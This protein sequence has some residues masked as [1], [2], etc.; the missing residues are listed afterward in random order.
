[1]TSI[2]PIQFV[3]QGGGA[4]LVSLLAAAQAV[5]DNAGP[6]GYKITRVSGTSA[7]AIAACILASGQSPALFLQRLH[8]LADEYLDKITRASESS[9]SLSLV[10]SVVQDALKKY[11][12]T[13]ANITIDD[14]QIC[15]FGKL[16]DGVPI[17]D[18]DAYKAFL[19]DLFD[20]PGVSF[21]SLD[22]LAPDIDIL[23]HAVDIRTKEP[24]VYRKGSGTLI[25]DAL[26]DSSALP[27]I[28]RTFKSESG[29]FDGGLVNNF[30]SANLLDDMKKYGRVLGFTFE[31]EPMT[32]KF[33]NVKDFASGLV[34]TMI[35]GSTQSSLNLLDKHCV[36]HIRTSTATLD[37]QGAVENDMK[38]TIRYRQYVDDA[39]AFLSN[40]TMRLKLAD[41]S[42]SPT[43]L[44]KRINELHGAL[45]AAQSVSTPKVVCYLTSN[46]LHSRNKEVKDSC[47]IVADLKVS[48]SDA[49]VFGFRL[50]AEK[51]FSR[52]NVSLIDDFGQQI[53][54]T[55]IP[56]NAEL[57]NVGEN[58]LLTNNI[59]LFFH[60]PLRQG[61]TYKLQFVT[62]ATEVL[63]D[64]I[65]PQA[66]KD[67]IS[68]TLAIVEFVDELALVAYIPRDFEVGSQP[69]DPV[70]S[71][72]WIAGA[73]L[74]EE[75]LAAYD[76][77]PPGFRAVG[78]N[79]RDIR[80]GQ[81][82][83]FTLYNHGG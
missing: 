21:K 23:V 66:R 10:R 36:H 7:G 9:P 22:D 16:A 43:G 47:R 80:R 62:D 56:L 29:I 50:H 55:A 57:V 53:R 82:V 45:L 78:W 41:A 58:V 35:D 6:L 54:V 46:S 11:L 75:A 24:K 8:I 83:G 14:A 2:L 42:L 18:P 60:K 49:T 61:K 27:F 15:L 37:F 34:A 44:V 69:M 48:G 33:S 63:Y 68:F 25:V 38:N 13:S 71:A 28:F 19:V 1:M 76:L 81:A 74:D 73:A 40:A 72:T 64:L 17:F 30:P 4:K 65:D 79:A 12:A 59:L 51:E 20:L 77:P 70:G 26:F 3:F 39:A 67:S 5:H 32:L 52:L 31:R